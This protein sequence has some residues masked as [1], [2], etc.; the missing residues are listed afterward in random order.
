[1]SL[2]EYYKNTA[3]VATAKKQTIQQ[4]SSNSINKFELIS[5]KSVYKGVA[6][7][8]HEW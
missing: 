6:T 5:W 1:M 8:F 7:K 4:G 3:A 2:T